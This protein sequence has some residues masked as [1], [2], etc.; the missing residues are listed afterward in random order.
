MVARGYYFFAVTKVQFG[1][2]NLVN[3]YLGQTKQYVV[4]NKKLNSPAV[5][6]I[7][8][9]DILE[10][11]ELAVLTRKNS[12]KYRSKGQFYFKLYK[13]VKFIDASWRYA[14]YSAVF[15]K[16]DIKTLVVWNGLKYNQLIMRLAAKPHNTSVLFMENGLIPGMTTIDPQG[17]NFSNSAPRDINHYLNLGSNPTHFSS[18]TE[19][20]SSKYIFVPFQVNTDSQIVRYSPWIKDMYELFETVKEAARSLPEEYKVL[21]R[22]HPMCPEQYGDLI[23]QI[24]QYKNISFDNETAISELIQNA[25]AIC[26][27]NST[28]GIEGLLSGKNV[29][30]LGEAF[31]KI[32]GLTYSA[33]NIDELTALFEGVNSLSINNKAISG[34]KKYLVSSYQVEGCWT[35]AKEFHLDSLKNKLEQLS[36]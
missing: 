31:Y 18:G 22:L 26:T 5:I 33:E 34:F 10:I 29:I 8:L 14:C 11:A 3:E 20:T 24:P 23:A 36:E 35:E 21:F 1:Y 9:K 30:V 17:V 4:Y 25:S 6:K 28:V 13:L 2:F 16:K 32:D 7:P 19:Q 15:R 27:I 12:V